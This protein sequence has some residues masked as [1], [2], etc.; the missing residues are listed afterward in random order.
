[1]HLDTIKNY[2]L[3][4]GMESGSILVYDIDS[5]GYENKAKEVT[6]LHNSAYSRDVSWS[7]K[8]GEV[9]VGTQH[10]TVTIWDVKYA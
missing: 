6:I 10:G 4:V 1:M 7:R 3:V 5:P 2:L 8:R 9:Y